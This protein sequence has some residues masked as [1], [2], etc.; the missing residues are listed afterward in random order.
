MKALIAPNEA[1]FVGERP[2]Y[3]IAEVQTTAFDVAPPLFWV[4]CAPNCT[5]ELWYY[6]VGLST[7]V[8][9]Q[10]DPE[11]PKVPVEQMP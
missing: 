1:F 5:P 8:A 2:A 10:I 11:P 9:A 7:C 6:D 3:R 4:E